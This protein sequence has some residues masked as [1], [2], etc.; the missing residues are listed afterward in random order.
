[1]RLQLEARLGLNTPFTTMIRNSCEKKYL[2]ST[3]A[4]IIETKWT[5]AVDKMEG[6]DFSLVY[7]FT[8]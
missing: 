8:V 5:G 2:Y 4:L 3:F 1:M 7:F 6:N